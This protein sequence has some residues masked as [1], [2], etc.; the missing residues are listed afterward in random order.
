MPVAIAVHSASRPDAWGAWTTVPT[1]LQPA[2]GYT[3]AVWSDSPAAVTVEVGMGSAG[4]EVSGGEHA[5]P[6]RSFKDRRAGRATT[7]H[8]H[9]PISATTRVA[10]R[11]RAPQA[12]ETVRVAVELWPP[13]GAP[14]PQ[15]PYPSNTFPMVDR[16][17]GRA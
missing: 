14:A 5:V 7:I 15:G 4:Q 3:V 12:N 17:G 10:A 13:P 1:T 8:V 11:V 9:E 6:P 16:Q 2:D